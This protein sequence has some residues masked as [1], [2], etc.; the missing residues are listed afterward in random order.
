MERPV[1]TTSKE[2]AEVFGGLMTWVGVAVIILALAWLVTSAFHWTSSN[3]QR[4]V[5]IG[6]AGPASWGIAR[7]IERKRNA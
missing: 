7:Y 4:S 3:W 1:P 2:L 5:V 6:I